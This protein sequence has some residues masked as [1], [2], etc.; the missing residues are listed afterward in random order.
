MGCVF[1][2]PLPAYASR[3]AD[4][5]RTDQSMDTRTSATAPSP[6]TD[7]RGAPDSPAAVSVVVP[8]HNHASFVEKCLRSIF[9]QTQQ[10]A[11]LVVIDDGSSDESA[12]IIERVLKDCP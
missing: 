7:R 8:S 9:Q 6:T 2:A 3:A 11:E 10:P 5:L 12:R 4:A 1:Y